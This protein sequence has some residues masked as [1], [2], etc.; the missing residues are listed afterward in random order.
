MGITVITAA[1]VRSRRRL[2]RRGSNTAVTI[3]VLLTVVEVADAYV[4]SEN[5]VTSTTLLAAT[6][7][8]VVRVAVSTTGDFLVPLVYKTSNSGS[9][10]G[11]SYSN[12][13]RQ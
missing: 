12:S 13:S 9:C 5:I 8:R 4:S 2:Q 7:A 11:S 6:F 1:E 10:N 3:V